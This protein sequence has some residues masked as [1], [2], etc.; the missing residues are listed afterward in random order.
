M[1]GG[2]A[3]RKREE[4]TDEAIEDGQPDKRED[5]HEEERGKPGRSRGESAVALDLIGA[6]SLVHD[7]EQDQQRAPVID[8]LRTWKTAPS[9]P[10]MAKV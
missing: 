8:S 9:R 2:E 7:A 1:A 6:V 10:L 4:L 5:G 3:A